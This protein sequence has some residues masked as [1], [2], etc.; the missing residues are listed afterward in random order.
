MFWQKNNDCFMVFAGLVFSSSGRNIWPF[1]RMATGRTP[2]DLLKALIKRNPVS[3]LRLPYPFI[4]S[5]LSNGF[6]PSV[7][8]IFLTYK[9]L[10]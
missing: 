9:R 5:A 6:Y 3:S 8:G 1:D 4:L 10:F 2:V 7:P